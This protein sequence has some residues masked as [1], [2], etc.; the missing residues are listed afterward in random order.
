MKKT[1]IL[2]MTIII[3]LSCTGCLKEY[4]LMCPDIKDGADYGAIEVNYGETYNLN[5]STNDDYVNYYSSNTSIATVS[6]DGIVKGI[7]DPLDYK[8]S[9]PSCEIIIETPH[10]G[11]KTIDV[12][13]YYK[14]EPC[15]K[16]ISN[17][18]GN[19][20]SYESQLSTKINYGF[21]YIGEKT[22][23]K[24][25]CRIIALDRSGKVMVIGDM[26]KGKYGVISTLDSKF[27][28]VFNGP[29]NQNKKISISP[30]LYVGEEINDY[31]KITFTYFFEFSDGTYARCEDSSYFEYN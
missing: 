19:M 10:A 22:V 27:D 25:T 1:I 12:T 29:I 9:F 20:T 4:Y 6:A 8:Y 21:T 16:L 2:L 7:A 5:V 3:M 30:H 18:D 23:N 17:Q 24:L 13:V 14:T 11:T 26:S 31:F 15:S 28:V